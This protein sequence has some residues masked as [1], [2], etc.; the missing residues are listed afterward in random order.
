MGYPVD[1]NVVID[2]NI[3]VSAIMS[4]DNACRKIL[5]YAFSGDMVPLVGTALFLEYEDVLSR[6]DIFSKRCPLD[7][8]RRLDF[9]DDVLSVAQ[10]VDIHYLWRPNLRDEGDNHILELAVAGQAR[11]VI[12]Q[13]IKDFNFSEIH[14]PEIE[15]IHPFD[16]FDVL[17]VDRKGIEQ[18][19][20]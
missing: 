9:L 1:M 12:S 20:H 15:V 2:T 7:R 18:W 10:W 19:Q 6:D 8:E 17:E 16:F 5:R 11:Y 4:R 14:L 13:N 3:L